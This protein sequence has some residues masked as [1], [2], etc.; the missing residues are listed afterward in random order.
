MGTIRVNRSN[1]EADEFRELNLA[2]MSKE[3]TDKYLAVSPDANTLIRMLLSVT[4]DVSLV[5]DNGNWRCVA[6][7]SV[8]GGAGKA[9]VFFPWIM[10]QSAAE[11]QKLIAFGFLGDVK[12]N[13]F[14][15]FY[16]RVLAAFG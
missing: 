6:V 13:E 14:R 3:I 1:T 7:V 5:P 16:G 8:R 9:G 4:K 15:H 11:Q 10:P 2:K 12:A